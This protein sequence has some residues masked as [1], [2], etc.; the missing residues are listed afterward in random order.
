MDIDL[1][2]LKEAQPIT[3]TIGA[4]NDIHE[5]KFNLAQLLVAL[6]N[7]VEHIEGDVRQIPTHEAISKQLRKAMGY[8]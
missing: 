3:I 1:P 2:T 4:D 6:R 7:I 8:A 5:F